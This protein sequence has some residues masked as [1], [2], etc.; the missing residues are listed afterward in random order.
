MWN[1]SFSNSSSREVSADD[2]EEE[3]KNQIGSQNRRK[4]LEKQ[5]RD[6]EKQRK[7]LEKQI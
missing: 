6:L 3:P 7:S 5:N 4:N 2:N 1:L